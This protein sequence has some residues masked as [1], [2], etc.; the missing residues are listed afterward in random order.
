M[1]FWKKKNIK[2]CQYYYIYESYYQDGKSKQRMVE[3][4]GNIDDVL[5]FAMEAFKQRCAS[6]DDHTS[7]A[8]A[9]HTGEF[10]PAPSP[11]KSRTFQIPLNIYV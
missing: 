7:S 3:Y 4:I 9:T 2:G 8:D 5:A 6:Q 11:R 1:A 10:K